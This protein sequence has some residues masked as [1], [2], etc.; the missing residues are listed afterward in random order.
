MLPGLQDITAHVD[1]TALIENGFEAGLELY[2]YTT[3]GVFLMNCGLP[4]ILASTPAD[5]SPRYLPQ[6]QAVQ[7]LASP[8]EMGERFKVMALGKGIEEALLGFAE[9]DRSVML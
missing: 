3:Q 6:V 8:A 5:D 4:E 9:G 1:F 2:G 7:K